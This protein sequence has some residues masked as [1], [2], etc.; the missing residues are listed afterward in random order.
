[1]VTRKHRGVM[2]RGSSRIGSRA[3]DPGGAKCVGIQIPP[4]WGFEGRRAAPNSVSLVLRLFGAWPGRE[5]TKRSADIWI[6]GSS[7]PYRSEFQVSWWCHGTSAYA[8]GAWG[9]D[10]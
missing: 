4:V 1:M 10:Q 3:E 8:L 9:E 6:S 2:E 5:S 7:I